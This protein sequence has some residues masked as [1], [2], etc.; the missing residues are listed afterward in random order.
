[1]G[2]RVQPAQG[3]PPGARGGVHPEP[4]G[5]PPEPHPIQQEALAA[6]EATR[7]AG[8]T[9]GLVVLATGLGPARWRFCACERSRPEAARPDMRAPADIIVD[10]FHHAAAQS[11]RRV[12]A[13]FEPRLRFL[14]GHTTPERTDGLGP[15][16]A[17]R[18]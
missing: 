11:S 15:A 4:V 1:L 18:R 10:E 17:L 2:G 7:A 3:P 6:F 16:H 9:A 13:W 12:I 8:N 5:P 14:L